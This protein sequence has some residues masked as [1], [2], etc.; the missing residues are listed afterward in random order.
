MEETRIVCRC[1]AK[2]K[3]P[4]GAAP[5]SSAVRCP[6]CRE[7][8]TLPQ[9]RGDRA[10]SSSS[11]HPVPP[12]RALLQATPLPPGRQSICPICQTAMAAGESSL[13]CP[14]CDQ[15][16]H[17][18]CWTEIGGCGTYGCSHAPAIEKADDSVQAPLSAWGDTK[19]CPACGEEIKAIAVRCRYCG[20]DFDSVDPMSVADLR[21]Q[22]KTSE[23]REKTRQS[24]IALFIVSLL[25]CAAPL[26]LI[27]ALFYVIPRRAEIA[28]SGP[29]FVIMGW[30]SLALS[31]L[32]CLLMLGL[33]VSEQW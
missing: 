14:G 11:A 33:F 12:D 27:I 4:A 2:L 28:K 9:Q 18:E 1:G 32:F 29:L 6:R 25:G 7:Q 19:K 5:A 3:L 21:R 8:I 13:T 15:I 30:T 26:T 16:H 31:A 17:H 10:S 23:K 22:A 24:V 20:T